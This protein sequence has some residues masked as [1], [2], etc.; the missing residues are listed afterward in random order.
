MAEQA[1][2]TPEERA[3]RAEAALAD[4]LAERNRLW[5]QLQFNRA[6]DHELTDLRQRLTSIEQSRWWRLGMPLRIARR[7]AG[8]PSWLL[9]VIL[10]RLRSRNG[11]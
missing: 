6:H 11:H 4:A 1:H 5:E 3:E 7:A 10:S 2:P 8:D 9:L